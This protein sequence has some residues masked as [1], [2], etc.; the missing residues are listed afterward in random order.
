MLDKRIEA[1][2][3]AGNAD[4]TDMIDAME[5]AG[6]VDLRG[7]EALPLLLEVL[8]ADG[9]R[10][11]RRARAG[12]ARSARGVERG[13]HAS[14]RLRPQR[15]VRR[16]AVAGDHGRVV[17]AAR[18]R[19]VRRGVGERPRRA[20]HRAARHARGSSRLGLQRRPLQSGQQGPAP[21]A[22]ESR[23]QDPW[24]RTYCGNGNLAACKTA[25]WGALEQAAADLETGV[26]QPERRRL[27]ACDRRRRRPAPGGRHHGGAGDPLDQPADLPASRAARARR[28]WCRPARPDATLPRC[29]RPRSC[30]YGT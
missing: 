5:D 28:V 17:D 23:S 13:E 2:I 9:A 3:A 10:R 24:S 29:P 25:L 30:R 21:G 16:P 6:T 15:R 12:H 4:R 7:Q 1:V 19:H 11:P 26:R 18:A 14:A 8:G 27:E 22:R 20:A